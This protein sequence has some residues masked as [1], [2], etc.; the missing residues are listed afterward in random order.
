MLAG[1]LVL[2]F[3][4]GLTSGTE[5]FIGGIDVANSHYWHRAY[6]AERLAG[7]SLPAWAP[8]FYSG[9]PFLANPENAVFYP[10]TVLFVVLPLPIAFTL[11]IL[12]HIALAAAGTYVFVRRLSGTPAAALLAALAFG[13]GGYVIDRIYAGHIAYVHVVA[14]LPWTLYCAERALRGVSLRWPVLAGG[15]LALA[16]LGGNPQAAYYVAIAFV[17]YFAAGIAVRR[18]ANGSRRRIGRRILQLLVTVAVV[19][20][21]CAVQ[22]LPSLEFARLS[23]RA[24]SSFAF[25]TSFS[26]PFNSLLTLLAPQVQSRSISLNWE[27][28]AYVGVITL[29]L[30]VLGVV[31]ARARRHVLGLG[32]V[33]LVGLVLALGANTPVYRL[34]YALVPGLDFFRIPARA[35]GI[36]VFPL[37][38]FAAL[39][40]D[41][42]MRRKR[43]ND[44]LLTASAAV[45]AWC[46]LLLVA[47][48]TL[49]VA[50]GA[51]LATP[52]VL[53]LATLAVLWTRKLPR[54]GARLAGAGA[55]AL[56]VIDLFVS[57]GG[58]VPL[59]SAA[60]AHVATPAERVVISAS[61]PLR[62]A[63]PS[64]GVRGLLHHYQDVD[65]NT[66]LII[67][68]YA[69]FMYT[70]SGQQPDPIHRNSLDDAIFA[71]PRA[72][73]GLYLNVRYVGTPG[74]GLGTL[75][76]FQPR[77]W[78]VDR[79]TV[80]R[81]PGR[82]LALLQS[83]GFDPRREAVLARPSPLLAAGA[84]PK[85]DE[86]LRAS[87][88]V[89]RYLPEH[90]ELAV[91]TERAAHLVLSEL[92]YPGWTVRIDGREAEIIT[93]DYLLRGV[94]VRA[95]HHRITFD[96]QPLSLRVGGAITL[97]TLLTLTALWWWDRSQH[98]TPP[99]RPRRAPPKAARKSVG[100]ASHAAAGGAPRA[101]R[102]PQGP[103]RRP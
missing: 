31:F 7:L 48:D 23:D 38:V 62:T 42:L 93:T 2:F 85:D 103:P 83:G 55:V 21:L 20:G 52:M 84:V 64:G 70:M 61:E 82:Q 9:H 89:T 4:A 36:V 8:Y 25:S 13:F 26:Y 41:A 34:F 67:G 5:V 79:V 44:L 100:V 57:F 92:D 50:W 76:P 10:L 63:L 11:D 30:A 17:C 98:R 22:I 32:I 90:I 58:K 80:E 97:L 91:D 77:A 24:E 51:G 18:K 87:V 86:P 27:M 59:V 46:L 68:R 14:W 33:A 71:S 45:V 69:R 35:L 72:F 74:G 94:G 49:G 1:V 6:L 60:A 81:D 88:S 39:G 102:R 47:H 37:A 12:V 56:L 65:G 40:L 43:A 96:Y 75:D 3:H 53:S 19:G 101:V 15:A 95:G 28:T 99:V 16:V 78:M 66:P 54:H 29:T 73:L